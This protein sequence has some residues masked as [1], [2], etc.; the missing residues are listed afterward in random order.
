MAR[1]LQKKRRKT[2]TQVAALLP[3]GTN[4]RG[5]FVGQ[6]QAR[7]TNTATTIVVVMVGVVVLG[8]L[9]GTVLIPGVLMFLG[10]VNAV[11]PFRYIVLADQGVASGRSLG[12]WASGSAVVIDG[13]GSHREQVD[14]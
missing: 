10:L 5:V 6:A 1:D 11:R 14:R 8:I 13:G 9:L 2:V 3:P 7:W 12:S 4:V